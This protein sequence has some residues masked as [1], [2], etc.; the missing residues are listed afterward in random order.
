MTNFPIL[1]LVAGMIFFYFLLSIIASSAV[2]MILTGL[3]CRAKMLENWL[4]TIF[5]EKVKLAGGVVVPLSQA[6]MNHCS[7][8]AS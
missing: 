2:E 7:L 1:D 4:T 3:K 5:S 8:T 6:I